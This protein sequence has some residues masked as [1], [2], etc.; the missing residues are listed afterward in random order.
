MRKIKYLG[1]WYANH[2]Y[3]QH[4]YEYTNFREA[5]RELRRICIGNTPWGDMG[6]WTVTDTAGRTLR[7]GRVWVGYEGGG[8]SSNSWDYRDARSQ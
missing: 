7:E 8:I 1:T 5:C 2:S 6:D 3:P 4:P